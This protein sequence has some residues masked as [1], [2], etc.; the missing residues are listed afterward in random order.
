MIDKKNDR[1]VFPGWYK[2]YYYDLEGNYIESR[3]LKSKLVP[4][5]AALENGSGGFIFSEVLLLI[6]AMPVITTGMILMRE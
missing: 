4:A 1:L 6:K 5:Q 2:F 3:N